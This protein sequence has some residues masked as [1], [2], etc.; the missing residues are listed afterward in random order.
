MRAAFACVG[1]VLLAC[2][3]PPGLGTLRTLPFERGAFVP[4]RGGHLQGVACRETTES[5]GCIVSA[6]SDTEAYVFRVEW[7]GEAAGRVTHLERL[8][9]DG[10]NHA[11]GIQRSGDVVAVGVEDSHGKRRSQVQLWHWSGEQPSLLSYLT[12]ERGG[13]EAPP[14]A[15]TAGAVGLTEHAGRHWLVVGNWD[16]ADLDFHR[17][18][19]AALA[20]P[21]ARFEPVARWSAAAADRGDW[22][23]DREWRSYQ[24]L[25]LFPA[26][27]PD[28]LLLVGLTD[29]SADFYRVELAPLRVVKTRVVGPLLRDARFRWGGGLGRG[30]SGG[31]RFWATGR[32]LSPRSHIEVV[33]DAPW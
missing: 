4:P 22:L 2:S 32:T 7:Q 21:S 24:S 27:Q 8:P 19:G 20:D 5:Y 25:Q 30:P 13:P 16:S 26:P 23:P 12:L 33:T 6:S 15:Y 29:R 28:R 1:L 3:Q 18:N 9:G 31:W 14:R 11:G 10:L 17:S